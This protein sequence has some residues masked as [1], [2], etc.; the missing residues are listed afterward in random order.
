MRWA[1]DEAAS[2]VG[3]VPVGAAALLGA[4]GLSFGLPFLY[5]PDEDVMVGR[6][7]HMAAEGSLDP[8]FQNYPPLVFDLFAVGEKLAAL[9]G[10]GTLVDPRHGDPTAA[11]LVG[12]TLSAAAAAVTVGLVFQAGRR[13]YGLLPA[14]VAASVLAL[15]P[16]AVRQAHFATT[17]GIQVTL[18]VAAMLA[19]ISARTGRGFAAAGA[20]C[21]LAAASKYTGVMALV[22][23]LAMAWHSPARRRAA[24]A[25]A[26]AAAAGFLLP[27]WVVLLHP[28]QYAGG[29][30]FL[31]GRGYGSRFGGSIGLIYH[32]TVTL[33]YGLGLGAYAL[34]LAGLGVALWRRTPVD[35]ALLLFIA[36]VLVVI[37]AGH[38]VFFRYALPLLPALA[39]LAGRALQELPA[40]A[41]APALLVCGLLLL[42]GLAASVTTDTLL[43]RTDS[44][45]L[46]ARWLDAHAPAGSRLD[47]AYYISPYYDQAE[48]EHQLRYTNGDMRA[49]AFL[50]GRYSD[51]FD[52]HD[53]PAEYTLAATG[54]RPLAEAGA[55]PGGTALATFQGAGQGGVYDPIDEFFLPIWGFDRVQRPG[56]DLVIIR[57]S[58]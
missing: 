37:G 39:L 44:R 57:A 17:D 18:M 46:A 36:A 43:T 4:W 38:E 11:Y 16:L 51:R 24:G 31:G 27:C 14:V 49:A 29:V 56:P 45:T 47:A 23:V 21:G 58:P 2:L 19:A 7:V 25:S 12:R 5:R 15:A 50:Q 30:L 32:P 13:A 41:R 54:P 34:A 48:V 8:L 6:A 3:L 10:L 9:V 42:P 52:L 40:A 28:M 1:R 55:G 20:L 35:R 26:G 22:F 53:R 33:P